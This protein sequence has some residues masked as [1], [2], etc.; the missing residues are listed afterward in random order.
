MNILFINVY[1]GYSTTVNV[2]IYMFKCYL[3]TFTGHCRENIL[4]FIMSQ[5]VL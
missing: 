1:K 3:G 4:Y 2:Y 5:V